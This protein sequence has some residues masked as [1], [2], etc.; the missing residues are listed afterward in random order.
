MADLCGA[1]T[2]QG[3]TCKRAPLA[4]KKRCKLHGGAT[5]ETNQNAR[6]H[7]IYSRFLTPEEQAISAEME[8]GGI[9]EELRLT[10]IRLMRALQAEND[11]QG[12]PELE[13]IVERDGAENVTAKREET[14]KRR[15]YVGII[16][17][18]TARIESLESRRLT[19]INQAL[20][21][22]LKR[23][24]L[25]KETGEGNLGDMTRQDT[26]ISPDEPVPENPIL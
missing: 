5:P 1:K 4:G 3:G 23:S 13:E 19:L 8:L 14:Y 18:L 15:D 20:D 7:G 12:Q 26:Y 17:R 24:Q 21:A 25:R 6:K 11:S 16:D 10:R 2:R 22:D 9:D